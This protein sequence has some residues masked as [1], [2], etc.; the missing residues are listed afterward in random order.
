M[1]S[2]KYVGPVDNMSARNRRKYVGPK[3]NFRGRCPRTPA[4]GA[5]PPAPPSYPPAR[6]AQALKHYY[7]CKEYNTYPTSEPIECRSG[8][9]FN[10]QEPSTRSYSSLHDFIQ[11]YACS[12]FLQPVCVHALTHCILRMYVLWPIVAHVLLQTLGFLKF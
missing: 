1:W 4:R 2:R 6:P 8:T 7:S 3:K 10:L 9:C 12:D 11:L 5:R